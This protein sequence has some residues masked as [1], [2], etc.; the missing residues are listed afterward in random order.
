MSYFE[1]SIKERATI[2]VSRVQGISLRHIARILEGASST[3]SREVR[4]NLTD[5]RVYCAGTH[6]SSGKDDVRHVAQ[7]AG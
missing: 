7:S 3:V 2:Q 6:S 5:Q 1:L 4:R